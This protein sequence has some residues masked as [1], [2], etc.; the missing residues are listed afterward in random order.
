MNKPPVKFLAAALMLVLVASD[1]G[2][3]LRGG[4]GG[5]GR[6]GGGARGGARP[7]VNRSPSM[8]RMPSYNRPSVQRPT[9]RP[10]S[11]PTQRPN[12]QRPPQGNRFPTAPGPGQ[13]PSTRPQPNRGFLGSPTTRPGSRPATT[14]PGSVARPGVNRPPSRDQIKSKIGNHPGQRPSMPSWFESGASARPARLP[15]N[16]PNLPATRP[17]ARSSVNR[18]LHAAHLPNHP[19]RPGHIRPWHSHHPGHGIHR[20]GYWWRPATGV[21]LTAWVANRWRQPVYYSYGT[22][23]SVYYEGDSVYVEGEPYSTAEQYYDEASTIAKSAPE[24]SEEA[25]E[26]MEWLPLGV[27]ALT[28]GDLSASQMYL[29]LAINKDSV[30]SGTFYNETSDVTFEVEGFVDAETQRAAWTAPDSKNPDVVME[31]GI[32]NLTQDE[33]DV[34]VHFGPDLTQTWKM[35]RLAESDRPSE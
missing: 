19:I 12:V 7:S 8:S 26:D 2:Y 5:G 25:A 28:S 35:V 9:P 11:R 15:N 6:G 34:L 14:F 16:R 32:Y 18:P 3:A 4:R 31:T 22:D 33:A 10:A 20:P 27:F 23:G 17:G 24:I 29:Q 21:V 30:I 1:H 13:R